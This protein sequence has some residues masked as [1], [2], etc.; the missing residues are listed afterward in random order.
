MSNEPRKATDVLLELETK[1]DVLMGLVRSQDL[2]IKILSNKLNEVLGKLEKQTTSPQK[3]TV[4]AINTVR[5]PTTPFQQMQ[6]SDPERQIPVSAETTLP[7]TNTPQGF[8]R[9]SRPETFAGD[10]AYLGPKEDRQVPKY[11]TQLL[12]PPPGRESPSQPAPEAPLPP[13]PVTVAKQD[14]NQAKPVQQIVQNAIPVVQRIVDKNGKSIFLADVEIIDLTTS[15]PMF[16]TRT[17]GT[18]KW[19]ASLG[20][21]AYRV[22]IRKQPSQ[23]REKI[24]VDQ[25]IKIDGSKSPLEL[26]TMIIR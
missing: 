16:K 17:N 8:R 2:N 22:S 20:V 1:V 7:S 26:Q 25:D 12:N 3:I 6:T 24:E 19:M 10:D 5:A 11:P 14:K 21:G 9:T 4:E 23:D 13:K 15:Q 18:G